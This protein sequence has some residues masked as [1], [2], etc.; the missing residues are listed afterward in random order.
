VAED[1]DRKVWISYNAPSYLQ[2]R[3]KLPAD[4]LP[5]I[6]VIEVVAANAAE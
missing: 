1:A 2:E 3:H 4:L 6:A 5:N